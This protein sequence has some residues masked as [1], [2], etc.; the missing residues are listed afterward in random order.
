MLK[1]LRW[2]LAGL[3]AWVIVV[4]FRPQVY[5]MDKEEFEALTANK[6]PQS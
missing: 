3:V 1:F 4:V 2:V 6:R 5:Q